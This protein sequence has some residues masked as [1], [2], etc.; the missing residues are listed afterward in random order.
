MR[1]HRWY[2]F[3]S[4]SALQVSTVTSA[5]IVGR[6]AVVTTLGGCAGGVTALLATFAATRAWDLPAT[7]NGILCG[8]VSITAG[9]PVFEP[10]AALI[11]APVATLA[12][13]QL[14][15]LVLRAGVADTV[16]ATAMHGG[17]GCLGALFVGLLAK[18]DYVLQLLGKNEGDF[19]GAGTYKGLF[20]G[21]NGKLLGAAAVGALPSRF[22]QT[23]R[24]IHPLD[25]MFIVAAPVLIAVRAGLI[26][27]GAWVAACMVPLFA[28]LR[29]AGLLRADAHAQ[30]VGLDEAMHGG[31]A[32][33]YGD[34]ALES[35]GACG[36]VGA[37]G[38]HDDDAQPSAARKRAVA[39]EPVDPDTIPAAAEP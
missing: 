15:R 26:A 7:C 5:S 4:G 30:A 19:E 36:S 38:R 22:V 17:V 20:Y 29:R 12:F 11:T 14:E 27:I 3:N 16:S 18:G 37:T 35:D 32:Y 2:G 23:G 25:P 31:P 34:A 1:G 13:A 8:L 9:A 39:A 24:C 21:G 6:A 33:F 28:A 10:W